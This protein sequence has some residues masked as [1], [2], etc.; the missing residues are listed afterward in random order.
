MLHADPSYNIIVDIN[1][2]YLLRI[3]NAVMIE[4]MHVLW[5]HITHYYG[6]WTRCCIHKAHNRG[7]HNDNPQ[8]K[9]WTYYSQQ[10][11]YPVIIIT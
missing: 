8:D 11:G 1:K 2:T 9:Q 6:C 7:L 3:V 5:N 4:E 10:T